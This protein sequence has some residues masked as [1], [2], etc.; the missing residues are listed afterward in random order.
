MGVRLQGT[1]KHIA[2]QLR[3]LDPF[4]GWA[5]TEDTVSTLEFSLAIPWADAKCLKLGITKMEAE[6]IKWW[7]ETTRFSTYHGEPGFD[8]SSRSRMA[9]FA[10]MAIS[11][12]ADTAIQLGGANTDLARKIFLLRAAIRYLMSNCGPR[13]M[14][15]TRR[16]KVSFDKFFCPKKHAGSLETITGGRHA[17][18]GRGILW[19]QGNN[20]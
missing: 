10:E 5:I 16:A 4:F 19:R 15:N 13:T 20:I 7:L 6:A 2:A 14:R 18:I 8:G 17:G 9:T 1:I 11:L 3:I 12:E